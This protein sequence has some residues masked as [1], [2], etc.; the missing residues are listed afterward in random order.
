MTSNTLQPEDDK[1]LRSGAPG[2][3]RRARNAADFMRMA[4]LTAPCLQRLDDDAEEEVGDVAP[5]WLSDIVADKG[6]SEGQQEDALLLEAVDD[7]AAEDHALD[8]AGLAEPILSLPDASSP[9]DMRFDQTAA[10]DTTVDHQEFASRQTAHRSEAVSG[11]IY[12]LRD[13]LLEAELLLQEMENQPRD[14][15]SDNVGE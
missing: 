6:E 5:P 3:L 13:R 8:E 12:G 7:G 9:S 1:R 4:G 11:G 15:A 10:A 14:G 2:A